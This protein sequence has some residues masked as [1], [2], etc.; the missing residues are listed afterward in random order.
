MDLATV[1]A[2]LGS[3]KTAIDIAKS[4]KDTD[5]SLEK[6]ET[7]LQLAELVSALADAKIQIADFQDLVLS[8]E[9]ENKKLLE[10]LSLKEN[11]T[12]DG[13]MY[14]MTK[15]DGKEDGPFCQKCK[16]T[17]NKMIRLQNWDT[18]WHCMTCDKSFYK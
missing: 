6:A 16:D 7:K 10:Q 2:S 4:L 8:K 14:W 5:L 11:I 1:T 17:D 9:Q 15:D 13:K 3:I 18:A 12:Y